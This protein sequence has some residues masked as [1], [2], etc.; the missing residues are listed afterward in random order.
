MVLDTDV[1]VDLCWAF[2]CHQ[3]T[4]ECIFLNLLNAPLPSITLPNLQNDGRERCIQKIQK[5]AF[6]SFLMATKGPTPF[7]NISAKHHERLIGEG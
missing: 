5:Y 7:K 1:F 6:R 3:E 2:R 4:S